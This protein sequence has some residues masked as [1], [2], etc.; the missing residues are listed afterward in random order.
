MLATFSIS[1]LFNCPCS[2]PV[3]PPYSA[4]KETDP[5]TPVCSV[6]TPSLETAS[7]PTSGFSNLGQP[8]V[9][10]KSTCPCTDSLPEARCPSQEPTAHLRLRSAADGTLQYATTSV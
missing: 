7:T 4:L 10:A 2:D 5:S 3:R 1:L 9:P 8:Q 6:F